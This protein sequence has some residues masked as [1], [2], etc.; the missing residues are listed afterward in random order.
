MILN[1]VTLTQFRNHTETFVRL[2]KG[3]NAF[4][5]NNGQGKTN[6][7][8]AIAYLSLTKSF[9]ASSD[10]EVL[11][12]EKEFFAVEG[13][14]TTDRGAQFT[15]AV[16]FDGMIREKRVT[17]NGHPQERLADIVG[18][19]PSVILSPEHAGIATGGPVER[20]RFLDLVLC[21]T[22]RAYL[23]DLL[24][25]RRI[26]RQ[27]NKILADARFQHL[28]VRPAIDPWNE[29]FA[30]YGS[31]L[32]ARR[33]A[34]VHAFQSRVRE[35]YATIAGSDDATALR[36]TSAGGVLDSHDPA[37]MRSWL[38]AEIEKKQEEEARRGTSLVGP[39]RDDVQLTIRGV[40]VHH[41]A[42][43]GEQKS[44][45]IALKIAEY[46]YVFD[47]KGERPLLLLDDVFSELDQTRAEHVLCQVAAMGQTAITATST[48]P[49]HRVLVEQPEHCRFT[50]DHGTCH[51]D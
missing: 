13:Q 27:R 14:F 26:L 29:S 28:S 16:R 23:E 51:P 35:A 17:V 44:L 39:H 24:E 1:E 50:V 34:F 49:F 10:A 32:M 3:I 43:Q 33:G 15:V 47:Q 36:Y 11:Q 46:Q 21:Q 5:G 19:F 31:R 42:S 22:S 41:F 2:G 40:D 25:Y 45:L 8:E 20:R 48:A 37:E 4:V 38:L 6:I 30:T 18:E 12:F 7:L 9:Y